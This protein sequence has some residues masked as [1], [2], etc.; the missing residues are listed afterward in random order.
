[1]YTDCWLRLACIAK[2][3]AD[4]AQAL[5]YCQKAV[6]VPGGS[7]DAQVGSGCRGAVI[8]ALHALGM[9][10]SWRSALLPASKR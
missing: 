5:E 8:C 10:S 2:Q 1:M 3:S 4:M 9:P 7:A 6:E